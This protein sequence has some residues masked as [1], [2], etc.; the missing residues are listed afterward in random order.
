[1]CGIA[2]CTIARL[3]IEEVRGQAQR[4]IKALHHRGPDGNGFWHEGDNL[5]LTHNRL[6]ILDLSE[7]GHQPMLSASGRYVLTFNGEIYNFLKLKS[8][9]EDAGIRFRGHSDTEVILSLVDAHGI[10]RTLGMIDGM[11]ALAFYDRE[12]MEITIA[13][14]RMGEKPLFYGWINGRFAFGSELKALQSLKYPL[15]IDKKC[16][17][18]FLSYGYVPTPYS[19]YKNIYKL[20]PGTYLTLA[21]RNN[22]SVPGLFSPYPDSKHNGPT[23]FWDLLNVKRS[24]ALIDTPEMAVEQLEQKLEDTIARQLVADVPVGCFLSGGIDSSLVTVLAQKQSIRPIRSF[25]IGFE[26]EEFNEAP[27]AR[28]IASHI[29]TDHH[30]TFVKTNDV[31]NLI[32]SLPNVYDEP[33]ADPSQLPSILVAQIAR[34]DVTVCLSG[35]GGDELFAGYNRYGAASSFIN[36]FAKWPRPVKHSLGSFLLGLNPGRVDRALKFLSQMPGVGRRKQSNLALKLRK[37]GV[38]MRTV[39]NDELYLFLLK[40]NGLSPDNSITTTILE[41]RVREFF[42]TPEDFITTVMLIDQ[43]NYLVDDN[44]TKVDR[45]AMSA[46]LETR[47]PLLDRQIVEHSWRIPTTVKLRDGVTKWPLREILYKYVPRSLIERPKMG[48][49]VPIASWLRNELKRWSFDLL[50]NPRLREFVDVDHYFLLWE[51]HQDG[52]DD[53][54]LVLWPVLILSQWLYEE[55]GKEVSK[56]TSKSDRNADFVKVTQNTTEL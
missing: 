33:F 28:E 10:E 32:S 7:Q 31:L 48:F 19:I 4:F 18:D 36:R 14:D 24:S 13:R 53:N 40:L 44:L 22:Y 37:L 26:V 5:L 17:G 15:E 45:S 42:D 11:F 1:M 46:S 39:G 35:D 34:K 27:F 38:L 9:M 55:G 56:L 50:E 52:L 21:K 29:G 23:K 54:G 8:E 3:S 30:E 12:K 2:G 43:L 41:E 20:V 6:A 25:T 51:R 49:S 16:I 47:L